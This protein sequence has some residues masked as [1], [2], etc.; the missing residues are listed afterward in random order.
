MTD[1]REH[2]DPV[3][4]PAS[5]DG[6]DATSATI[7]SR[8]QGSPS[9]QAVLAMSLLRLPVRGKGGTGVLAAPSPDATDLS[10]ARHLFFVLAVSAVLMSSIDQTIVAV[11]LPQMITALDSPLL[12]VGWSITA[13]QLV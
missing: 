7:L 5:Y 12:Y 2:A 1:P 4:F 3:R 9:V 6:T 10:P 11:A 13:Y 8:R